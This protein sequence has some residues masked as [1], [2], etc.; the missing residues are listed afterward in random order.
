MCAATEDGFVLVTSRRARRTRGKGKGGA[1]RPGDAPPSPGTDPKA[2]ST[3]AADPPAG[4]ARPPPSVLSSRRGKLHVR[5]ITPD[6]AA[7]GIVR[8]VEAARD[9]LPAPLLDL[10]AG[11]LD[12]LL[13]P[14]APARFGLLSVHGLGSPSGSS[15]S[16]AQAA[17]ALHI[18]G[19]YGLPGEVFDPD[20][21]EADWA[22]LGKLGFVRG[23]DLLG[24][25]ALGEEPP[26]TSTS[27]GGPSTRDEPA[28]STLYFMPHCELPLYARLASR[29]PPP[30]A[31]LGNSFASYL[32]RGAPGS[33]ALRAWVD[34]GGR[35]VP[36][37]VTKEAHG[38]EAWL[39]LHSCSLHV[40][41][42]PGGEVAREPPR[43]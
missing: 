18:M 2:G 10:L 37:R 26:D 4:A 5:E 9:R 13:L 35:E 32:D 40:P 24:G 36:L 8:A 7:E 15:V 41:D 23:D 19:R 6:E 27:D 21:T 30:A 33:A 22:A 1:S 20:L 12:P 14:P 28:Q 43:E 11:V 42:R 39:A 29:T 17:I 3:T 38:E 31:I 34:A 25:A 16:R